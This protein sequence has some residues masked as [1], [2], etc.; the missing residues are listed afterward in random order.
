MNTARLR[1][2]GTVAAASTLYVPIPIPMTGRITIDLAWKDAT[3]SAAVTF[4][5]TMFD[6]VEAPVE[7]AGDAWEWK[8]EAGVPI[9]GPAAAAAG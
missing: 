4:E 3:S 8:A 7:V 2:R 9:T 6:S 1:F 5:T